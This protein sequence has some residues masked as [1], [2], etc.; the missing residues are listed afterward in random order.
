VKCLNLKYLTDYGKNISSKDFYKKKA[1]ENG[2]NDWDRINKDK[3]LKT[4]NDTGYYKVLI[5][6]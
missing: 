3:S 4:I 1:V 5:K 6:N 2:Y